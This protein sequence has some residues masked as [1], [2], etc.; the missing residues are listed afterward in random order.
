MQDNFDTDEPKGSW[1][2]SRLVKLANGIWQ[3]VGRLYRVQYVF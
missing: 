2:R 3:R 1:R